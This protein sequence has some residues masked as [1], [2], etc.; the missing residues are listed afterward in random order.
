MQAGQTWR[1]SGLTHL[2]L[3]RSS[4]QDALALSDEL[5]LWVIADGMGG[6]AGG[7]IAS[8]IAV[9]TIVAQAP[10]LA[11]QA[12]S[13]GSRAD[14][15]RQALLR[16]HE[17]IRA[18]AGRRPALS[19]MG[20]TAVALSIAPAFPLTAAIAHVGD[21]RAYL[22]RKG[23]LTQLTA[24]HSWV[25]ERL[26]QGL[27]SPDE[28]A[29]HPLRHMLTRALGNA[30]AVE[31]DV[32]VR[33]LQPGDRLLLCTDGLTKMLDNDRI[34]EILLS[35]PDGTACEALLR[36]ALARGGLDNVTVLLVYPDVLP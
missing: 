26:H 24:D 36:E 16:A 30:P 8:R 17:A 33:D 6:H 2:G 12:D 22:C 20:T 23:A 32:Q 9:D 11:A 29:V 14:A 31:V 3:V 4:N 27:L 21:S 1:S 25:E 18:E 10:A 15:L 19:D 28:A 7:D 5:G 35:H 34:L 13:P